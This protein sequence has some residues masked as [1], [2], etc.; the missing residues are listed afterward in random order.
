MSY[1][2]KDKLLQYS[3]RLHILNIRMKFTSFY[4]DS[5]KERVI[6]DALDGLKIEEFDF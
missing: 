3:I 5:S 1:K 4:Y 2:L 6:R